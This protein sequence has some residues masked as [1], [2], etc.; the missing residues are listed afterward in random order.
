[1]ATIILSQYHIVYF[2][3][4]RRVVNIRN[5]LGASTFGHFWKKSQRVNN[6]LI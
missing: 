5:L 3:L 4:Y 6:K 2:V 1:M